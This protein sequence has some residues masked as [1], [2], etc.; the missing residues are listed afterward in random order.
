MEIYGFGHI[1][2]ECQ[3][4]MDSSMMIGWKG[5]IPKGRICAR[6]NSRFT[7]DC[8]CSYRFNQMSRFVKLSII[9]RH[10]HKNYSTIASYYVISK[11]YIICKSDKKNES[12]RFF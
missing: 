1:Q 10:I 8:I 12:S 7:A 6:E 3:S 11:Q 5:K 2:N 4:K 9:Q